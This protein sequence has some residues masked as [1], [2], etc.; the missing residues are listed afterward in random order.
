[1]HGRRVDDPLRMCAEVA[2]HNYAYFRFILSRAVHPSRLMHTPAYQFID[3]YLLI[4]FP[5][6][7]LSVSVHV[8]ICLI[9]CLGVCVMLFPCV[10][11]AV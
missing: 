4:P 9:D 6:V 3:L 11:S 10:R 2:E 7:Y 8:S 1:M 5:S